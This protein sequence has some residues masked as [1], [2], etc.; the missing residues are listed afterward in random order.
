[1]NSRKRIEERRLTCGW[2]CEVPYTGAYPVVQRGRIYNDEG[3]KNGGEEKR[4][5]F[6][7][8]LFID[9]ILLLL[10]T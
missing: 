4:L 10:R 2:I 9:R 7:I 1:M 3:L 6:I 5:F 8:I